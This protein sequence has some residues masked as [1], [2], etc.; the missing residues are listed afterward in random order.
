MLENMQC[1]AANENLREGI[2]SPMPKF[3]DTRSSMQP[4]NAMS[5]S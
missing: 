4:K 2:L 3:N 1:D 5:I